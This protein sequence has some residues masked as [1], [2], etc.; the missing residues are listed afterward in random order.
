MVHADEDGIQRLACLDLYGRRHLS[1]RRLRRQ[2]CDAGHDEARGIGDG[3]HSEVILAVREKVWL[4][5]A[6]GAECA[7]ENGQQEPSLARALTGGGKGKLAGGRGAAWGSAGAGRRKVDRTCARLHA[8][9][10][11]AAATHGL[12]LLVVCLMT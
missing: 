5:I 10:T 3:G 2:L 1:P 11:C 9:S 6:R 8:S 4:K 12:G 7:S